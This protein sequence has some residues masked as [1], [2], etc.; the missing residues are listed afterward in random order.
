VIEVPVLA[1]DKEQRTNLKPEEPKTEDIRLRL[2]RW[3]ALCNLWYR[4]LSGSTL[5]LRE[6]I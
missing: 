3:L 6:S 4:S 5:Y 2:G 1:E